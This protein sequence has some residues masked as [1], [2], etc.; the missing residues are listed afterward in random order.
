MIISYPDDPYDRI[1]TPEEV[2]N[3]Y[4]AV[5]NNG[6]SIKV[7]VP[8]MPP[9]AVLMNAVTSSSTSEP[10]ILATQVRTAS[11][12]I[13]LIMY[14]SEVT[15]LDSDQKRSFV[16]CIDSDIASDPIV[17][18]YGSVF[19]LYLT[20]T[21]A[22]PNTTFSLI[23]TT[24][25]TL[26]PL[27]NAMELFYVVELT[28]GTN[29]KDGNWVF[30]INY[31]LNYKLIKKIYILNN[32]IILLYHAVEGLATLQSKFSVLKEWT[33]DPCLPSTFTWDWVNCSSDPAPRVTALYII[34]CHI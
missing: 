4:T 32:Y 11:I 12:P 31:V 1:W 3:G 18:P 33:G 19:E 7:E 24:D 17:P 21:T 6:T 22:T 28:D 14:F 20:N 13:Y 15:Q 23:A 8:E 34:I 30:Y 25:S 5:T 27:I 2:D 26:P 29:S 10:L 16:F 9:E